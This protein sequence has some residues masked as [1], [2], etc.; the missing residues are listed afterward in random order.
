MNLSVEESLKARAAEMVKKYR[1][2][3]GQPYSLSE[4]IERCLTWYI[5]ADEGKSE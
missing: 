4:L 5:E 3:E 2:I 1:H